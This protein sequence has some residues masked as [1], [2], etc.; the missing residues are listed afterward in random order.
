MSAIISDSSRNS[1]FESVHSNDSSNS[2]PWMISYEQAVARRRQSDGEIYTEVLHR[3]LARAPPLGPS[4]Y[5]YVVHV[6]NEFLRTMASLDAKYGHTVATPNHNTPSERRH[7]YFTVLGCGSG[8]ENQLGWLTPRVRSE[9]ITVS[10][11]PIA[12]IPVPMMALAAGAQHN[13]ALSTEGVP[14]TWGSNDE[15]A[16]G[17]ESNV[18]VRD[19]ANAFAGRRDRE[20]TPTP[21]TG[22]WVPSGNGG[23][24]ENENGRMIQ[25]AAGNSHSLACTVAGNV[26]QWGLYKDAGSLKAR[27]VHNDT[28]NVEGQN[29]K[30]VH[31]ASMPGKVDWIFAGFDMSA[32]ILEDG[33]LVTWGRF[34]VYILWYCMHAC[35]VF[36]STVVSPLCR[37]VVGPCVCKCVNRM[38]H[39]TVLLAR[40]ATGFG[41]SGQ[42]ARS[43]DMTEPNEKGEYNLND[44]WYSSSDGIDQQIIKEHFLTPKPVRWADNNP[45][46]KHSVISVGLGE[47]HMLVAAR[48]AGTFE[49]FVYVSGR[50]DIGQLGLGEG[51]RRVDALTMVRLFDF[52]RQWNE[53]TT[54]CVYGSI[55]S[56]LY[57]YCF[58]G[59]FKIQVESLRG[60]NIATVACGAKFSMALSHDGKRLFSFGDNESG[61]LGIGVKEDENGKLVPS[62]FTPQSVQFPT[63]YTTIASIA[64]GDQH[65]AAVTI[66]HQVYTW[67][68]NEC[69]QAGFHE[70]RESIYRPTLLDLTNYCENP[71]TAYC[72]V[73]A[74][75][76]GGQFT[77]FLVKQYSSSEDDKKR[78]LMESL[79]GINDQAKKSRLPR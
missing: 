53:R 11:Q 41:N 16:L 23:G 15:G 2:A 8:E 4:T 33:T 55:H 75:S 34:V 14:Y 67:G 37:S 5:R 32:A 66:D 56:R 36:V 6:R 3:C 74:V 62:F 49:S 68:Y 57:S 63:A 52:S 73:H 48:H 40:F 18:L 79:S 58:C 10:P 61:Q 25:I 39:T 20:R 77:M 64:A 12:E 28:T 76:C 50:G 13:V 45:V 70:A 35:T 27:I 19:D 42:L 22:F 72:H 9:N 54:S 59:V 69:R 31:M 30:P 17:R 78:K 29:E 47:N 38:S 71:S 46:I 24:P 60:R 7:Y 1:S 51:T 43:A 21:V 26:Y 65:S 44:N